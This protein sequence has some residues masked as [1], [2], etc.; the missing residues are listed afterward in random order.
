[1]ATLLIYLVFGAIA[2]VFAGLLGVGGG[3]ILVP[4][5][6]I[7][8]AM[9]KV[10]PTVAH[11][12]ALATSMA[13]IA[14][15]SVS[16]ARSHNKRGTIRWDIVAAMAP[17]IMAGTMGGTFVVAG[18]PA[19][20]LKLVFVVFLT[21]TSMQMI[22]DFKPKG[23]FTLPGRPGL[24]LAGLLIGTIAS[25]IGIGGGSLTIPFLVLSNVPM[26]NAIGI[27]AAIGFPLAVAGSI[28]F[29]INGLHVA[30]LPAQSLGFIYLPALAG[31]VCASMLTAPLG[32]RLSHCLPVKTLK[33]CFGVLLLGMSIRMVYTLL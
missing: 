24:I 30:D 26:I 31:L 10:S 20:P 1:M 9:E 12:M 3:V 21:Y 15:T 32:V 22:L 17:G 25:F 2:G 23:S 27:S 8:L 5:L 13:S 19:I 6:D 7:T 14:F 4:I 29:I 18:V 28:G 16:S 11:H 33:R